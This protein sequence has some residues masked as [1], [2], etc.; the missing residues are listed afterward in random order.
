MYTDAPIQ[1][2]AAIDSDGQLYFATDVGRFTR[3]R[4]CRPAPG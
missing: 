1:S 2:S 4:L 3:W